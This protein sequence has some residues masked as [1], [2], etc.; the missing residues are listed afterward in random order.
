MTERQRRILLGLMVAMC[1]YGILEHDAH[2]PVC[3]RNKL[4]HDG[5]I[6]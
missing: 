1:I 6:Q 5:R 2:C 3:G 4:P